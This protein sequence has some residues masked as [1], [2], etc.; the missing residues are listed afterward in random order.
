ML[1]VIFQKLVWTLNKLTYWPLLFRRT[2][3]S[4]SMTTNNNN[5]NNNNNFTVSWNPSRVLWMLW[6]WVGWVAGVGGWGG[7]WVIRLVTG[8]RLCVPPFIEKQPWLLVFAGK[9]LI[10]GWHLLCCLGVGHKELVW[11]HNRQST[12]NASGVCLCGVVWW[13]LRCVIYI[14]TIVQYSNTEHAILTILYWILYTNTIL[15][16]HFN[17]KTQCD[18]L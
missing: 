7:W 17:P 15:L 11:D 12:D 18:N 14:Y 4:P 3:F 5:N 9:M 8:T 1:V 16:L 13:V 6:G 2:I 10:Q